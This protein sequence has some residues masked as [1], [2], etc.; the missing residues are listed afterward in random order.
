MSSYVSKKMT[1]HFKSDSNVE[2]HKIREQDCLTKTQLSA[3][4]KLEVLEVNPAQW[5]YLKFY[6]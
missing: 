6:L 2:E 3:N 4:K 1:P 5:L